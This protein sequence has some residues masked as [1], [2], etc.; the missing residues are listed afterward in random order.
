MP[1]LPEPGCAAGL[2]GRGA[3]QY[4]TCALRVWPRALDALSAACLRL[5]PNCHSSDVANTAHATATANQPP[6]GTLFR[7]AE[8][9]TPSTNT[10]RA[11]ALGAPPGS[12]CGDPTHAQ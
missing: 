3:A 2:P 8:K 11:G 10:A 1:R 4:L 7:L 5:V 9:Y 12:A 6:M